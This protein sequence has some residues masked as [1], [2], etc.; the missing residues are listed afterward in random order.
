MLS[1]CQDC[2]YGTR[3][4]HH[5]GDIGCALYPEYWALWHRLQPDFAG[6]ATDLIEDCRE[7]V[8]RQDLQPQT[9]T[10]SATAQ[11]WRKLLSAPLSPELRQQIVA[12]LGLEEG[13]ITMQEV[14]S[15]NVAAIGHDGV[16]YSSGKFC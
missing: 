12:E 1:N 2:Q 16:F 8:L 14:D 15:S 13:V 3:K 6:I 10:L 4:R 11:Q 7:F 9:L 5:P